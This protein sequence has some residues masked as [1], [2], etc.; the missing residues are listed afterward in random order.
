MKSPTPPNGASNENSAVTLA[1][2][3]RDDMMYA[4]AQ[5]HGLIPD[6]AETADS[7]Y[8]IP[9]NILADLGLTPKEIGQ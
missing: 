7:S 5:E 4:E 3:V 1:E 2:D 9:D 6:D 8:T